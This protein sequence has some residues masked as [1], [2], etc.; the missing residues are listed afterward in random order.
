MSLT[1]GSLFS[2]GGGGDLGFTSAGYELLFGAEIDAKARAVF[3]WHH[4]QTRI[5]HDVKEIT[6]ERLKSDRIGKPTVLIG[7]SPCQDLSYA[8]RRAGLMGER[9]GLFFE[10]IRIADALNPTF[11]I[12]E[13]V[14][15]AFTSNKGK[16]FSEVIGQ[17][18]GYTPAPP[19]NGWEQGGLCVGPKRTAVWRVLDLSSFGPPQQRRRLFVIANPRTIR[20]RALAAIL[21]DPEGGSWNEKKSHSRKKKPRSNFPKRLISNYRGTPTEI[22]NTIT[23]GYAS[24][25]RP[26]SSYVYEQDGLRTLTPLECERL[27]GW[28]DDYT[29][30]GIDDN[31][32]EIQLANTHRYRICGNG[33]G[34]PVTNYIAKRIKAVLNEH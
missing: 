32:K 31:G 5:Y 27:M 17:I 22:V 13:N 14:R 34:A 10:Q 21:Y 15:G 11:V 16:D 6:R 9:S 7:G 28:P 23:T 33:I 2:G 19:A 3:R 20:P 29:A 18:T 24:R 25:L 12:W 30:K 4:P 26:D 8:G 1:V